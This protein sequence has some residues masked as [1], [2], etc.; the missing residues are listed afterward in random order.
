M[1]VVLGLK[2]I[3]TLS[4]PQKKGADVKPNDEIN[5]LRIAKWAVICSSP[6]TETSPTLMLKLEDQK[7]STTKSKKSK[8]HVDLDA[9]LKSK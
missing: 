8:Y 9:F 5:M 1:G 3:A 7:R 6:G 2:E 4:D